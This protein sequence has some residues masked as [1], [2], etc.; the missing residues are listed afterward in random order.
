MD[1]Q[2]LE[3]MIGNLL[4]A[5]V[6]LAAAVVFAGGAFYLAQ[7]YADRVNYRNFVAGTD[8]VSTLPGILHSAMQFQSEGWITARPVAADRH[9][10]SA[11]CLGGG[12]F[13]H[14]AG[15]ALRRRQPDCAGDSGGESAQGCVTQI[16]SR[17]ICEA[18]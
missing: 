15:P 8:S 5:G 6:L 18:V 12:G 11:C 2:R 17:A 10:R 4:R 1:D 13:C 14:G 16:R 9:A 3:D 7:H